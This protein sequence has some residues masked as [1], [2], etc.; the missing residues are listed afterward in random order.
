MGHNSEQ[1]KVVK[2]YHSRTAVLANELSNVQFQKE[3]QVNLLLSKIDLQEEVKFCNNSV[4]NEC[5]VS[6]N[7]FKRHKAFFTV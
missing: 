6:Q 5:Q 2:E 1:V 4:Q 7:C 3:K